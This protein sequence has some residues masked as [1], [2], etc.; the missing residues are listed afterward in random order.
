MLPVKNIYRGR[1]NKFYEYL[2]SLRDGLIDDFMKAHPN[3]TNLNDW[4]GDHYTRGG[5]QISIIHYDNVNDKEDKSEMRT[6]LAETQRRIAKEKYPT[7]H[8]KILEKFGKDCIVCGYAALLPGAVIQRHTGDENR[9]A[10]NIRIHIPLI[11]P[12]GD[13]GMEVYGEAIDWSDLFCFDNQKV[14]SVWNFTKEPR[15]ILLLDLKRDICGLPDGEPWSKE[16]E[17]TAPSF[18]KLYGDKIGIPEYVEI[19]KIEKN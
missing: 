18:P 1:E 2:M 14:H 8:D 3:F 11:V 4:G 12:E 13:I 16:S 5:W 7:V 9:Q 6:E 17:D 15:L 19:S 10:K